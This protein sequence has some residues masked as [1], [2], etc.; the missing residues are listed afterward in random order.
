MSNERIVFWDDDGPDEQTTSIV[1][2]A[3]GNLDWYLSIEGVDWGGRRVVSPG[4]RA[5]TSGAKCEVVTTVVA[6]L[7]AIGRGD[8][9]HALVLAANITTDLEGNWSRLPPE[10]SAPAKGGE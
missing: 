1:I 2:S 8:R 9:A 7:A 10:R 4:F 3:G 6:L 5:S